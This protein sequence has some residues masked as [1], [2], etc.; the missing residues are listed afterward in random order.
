MLLALGP[1][2]SVAQ[3]AETDPEPI[4]ST[5]HTY[6]AKYDKAEVTADSEKMAREILAFR[7]QME[8]AI[9]A[10]DAAKLNEYLTDDYVV[11]LGAGSVDDKAGRIKWLIAGGGPLEA[12]PIDIYQ[13]RV[14]GKHNAILTANLRVPSKGQASPVLRAIYVYTKDRPTHDYKGWRLAASQ[15]LRTP[16]EPANFN[17]ATATPA[18]PAAP[19]TPPATAPVH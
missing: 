18:A 7:T 1:D 4:Y 11:T 13:L 2:L 9:R 10:R 14:L 15:A 3:T 5:W 17:G 16:V 12:Q 6:V 19:M 8:E